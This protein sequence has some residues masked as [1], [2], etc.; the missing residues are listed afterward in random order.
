MPQNSVSDNITHV[1]LNI[2]NGALLVVV[3]VRLHVGC[4][5]TRFWI[6]VSWRCSRVDKHKPPINQIRWPTRMWRAVDMGCQTSMPP[7]KN[8]LTYK[9]NLLPWN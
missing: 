9:L 1:T 2:I 8:F 6:I 4:L 3:R 5:P 7:V